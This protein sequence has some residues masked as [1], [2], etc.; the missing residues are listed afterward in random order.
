MRMASAAA[1]PCQRD[2]S[3]F[4]LITSNF[5]TVAAVNQDKYMADILK[6]FDFVTVKTASTPIKTNKALLKDEEAEDVI[7][8]A[9]V[10][11]V[12]Y[13]GAS[14]EQNSTTAVSISWQKN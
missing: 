2:S 13:A 9:K 14:H 11:I 7:A 3:E 1:K 5:L 10:K 6:K 8:C 12:N 4:Y